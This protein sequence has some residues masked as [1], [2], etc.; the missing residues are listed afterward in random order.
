MSAT[1]SE[2]PVLPEEPEDKQLMYVAGYIKSH[3]L[4][5]LVDCG[6]NANYISHEIIRSLGIPTS[7]KKE[8]IVVTFGGGQPV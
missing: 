1:S 4:D 6:A 8:P 5:V 3:K 7:R 2:F